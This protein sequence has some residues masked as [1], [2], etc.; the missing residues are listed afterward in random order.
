MVLL[1]RLGKGERGRFCGVLL[2]LG[3]VGYVGW[4]YVARG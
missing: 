4:L 2:L 1:P 3:Y